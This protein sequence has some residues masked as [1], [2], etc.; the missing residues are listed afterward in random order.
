M[1]FD[2]VAKTNLW[3]L[4]IESYAERVGYALTGCC[5]VLGVGR[6]A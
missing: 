1:Y 3:R 4:L 2:L 5:C 6:E